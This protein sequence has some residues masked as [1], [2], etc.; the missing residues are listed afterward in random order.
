MDWNEGSIIELGKI[1]RARHEQM[2][3]FH[4]TDR[5]NFSA[6]WNRYL[7]VY[8]AVVLGIQ[9]KDVVNYASSLVLLRNLIGIINYKNELVAGAI[10]I[11]NPDRMGQYILMPRDSAEKILV[12]GMI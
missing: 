8:G 5:R 9:K 1:V 6:I 2:R 3:V 4:K 7:G 12:L 11:D 10:M